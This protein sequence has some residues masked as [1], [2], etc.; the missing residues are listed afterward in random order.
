MR[1]AASWMRAWSAAHAAGIGLSARR[2]GEH[3]A[4]RP[5][6]RTPESLRALVAAQVP[7]LEA[8]HRAVGELAGI[9]ARDLGLGPADVEAVVRAARVHDVGKVDVPAAIL[10]K[11]GPLDEH[12]LAA[13]REHTV[14]GQR[15]L[16]ACPELRDTAD[17]VRATHERWDGSGY[18]DALRGEEIPLGARIIAVCDAYDAMTSERPYRP[19]R[20]SE[21]ALAELH[22]GAG[23]RYDPR[24]VPVLLAAVA[25]LSPRRGPS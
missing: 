10:D 12:E 25:R 7:R 19:A 22:R 9:V 24:I 23:R 2:R 21:Q 20:T 17:V 3:V 13:M 5:L 16:A 14:I 1:S 6:R 15:M 8:H 11:R 4:C 18:P